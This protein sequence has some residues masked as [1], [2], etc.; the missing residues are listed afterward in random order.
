MPTPNMF[1]WPICST[2]NATTLEKI[3]Q[4]YLDAGANSLPLASH[5][6]TIADATGS[7]ST[8]TYLYN[9]LAVQRALGGVRF[10]MEI[11]FGESYY[12][13][14]DTLAPRIRRSTDAQVLADAHLPV[15][16]TNVA[17]AAGELAGG[18]KE[19]IDTNYPLAGDA[20]YVD[21]V[22]YLHCPGYRGDEYVAALA[23]ATEALK[24]YNPCGVHT[25]QEFYTAVS[26]SNYYTGWVVDGTK[27]WHTPFNAIQA[28]SRCVDADGYLTHVDA[29]GSAISAAVREHAPDA[30]LAQFG[31]FDIGEYD[32]LYHPHWAYGESTG[33][34][35]PMYA[36]YSVTYDPDTA[37]YS[38]TLFTDPVARYESLIS[39]GQDASGA[40]YWA[41]APLGACVYISQRMDPYDYTA[42]YMTEQMV[43]DICYHMACHGATRMALW[44]GYTGKDQSAAEYPPG[45]DAYPASQVL[46][47]IAA[48]A[49]LPVMHQAF[50]AYQA[51]VGTI[52]ANAHGWFPGGFYPTG[53]WPKRWWPTGW[54]RRDLNVAAST[55]QHMGVAASTRQHMKVAAS[56]RQHMG[57]DAETR[58]HMHVAASTRPHMDIEADTR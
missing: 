15:Y 19:L 20:T 47:D 13:E 56:S 24:R 14:G 30:A 22:R 16:H 5:T 9:A 27:E 46:D 12:W 23:K 43:Y 1:Y 42:G 50:A 45:T 58:Q 36:I 55:R 33:F 52:G 17:D 41:D 10:Q 3:W 26:W 8:N 31:A 38:R 53:W 32:R 57:V 28:C 54:P 35:T 48:K 4:W 25:E 39:A 37:L 34:T 2:T 29:I 44:P 11:H 7:R 6:R 18:L 40:Q 51:Q 49:L 21:R